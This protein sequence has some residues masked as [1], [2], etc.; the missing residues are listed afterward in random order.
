MRTPPAPDSGAAPDPAKT[1]GARV[2]E[3]RRGRG[4]TLK[5]VGEVSR[6]SHAF[7]S[8]F[9]RG[10]AAASVSTL[11]RI[12]VALDTTVSALLAGPAEQGVGLLR[13]DEGMVMPGAEIPTGSTARALSRAGFPVQPIEYT[14][15]PAEFGEYFEHVGQEMLYVVA[16]RI[17]LDFADGRR[18]QLGEADVATYPGSR[19]HRWRRL[20]EEPVRV[21]LINAGE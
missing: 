9:E 14:G 1:L 10:L 7:L 3:L 21:L 5:Q 13:A 11:Q 8:Q 2:R 17:E 16:G 6:L 15:G 4:L 20:G 12:A 18:E 19:P